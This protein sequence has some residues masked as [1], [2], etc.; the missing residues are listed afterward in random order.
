MAPPISPGNRVSL[1]SLRTHQ[2]VGFVSLPVSLS[3]FLCCLC[4]SHLPSWPPL[5]ASLILCQISHYL[6][7]LTI[8]VPKCDNQAQF[9]NSYFIFVY[10][11]VC[12]CMYLCIYI[13]RFFL[14]FSTVAFVNRY[15]ENSQNIGSARKLVLDFFHHP[16]GKPP[17]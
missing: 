11:Y 8:L 14:L 12:V 4:T 10:A 1:S 16:Y 2:S 15:L 7:P 3:L 17:Y 6:H 13:Y 9:Y 5:P